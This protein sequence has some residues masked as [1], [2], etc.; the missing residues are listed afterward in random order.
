MSH[1]RYTDSIWSAG[2]YFDPKEVRDSYP[3]PVD[4]SLHGRV[5]TLKDMSEDEIAAL[6]ALYTARVVRT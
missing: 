2:V 4:G 5:R 3:Q 1:I 6:E